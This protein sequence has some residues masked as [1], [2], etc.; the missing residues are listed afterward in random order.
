MANKIKKNNQH[1]SRP[2][3]I[4]IDETNNGTS[5]ISKNPNHP[6][7][8]IVTGYL[9]KDPFK[10]NYGSS[11]YEGKGW[12]FGPKSNLKNTQNR[13]RE[14]L[15]KYPDFYYTF[16]SRKLQQTEPMAILKARAI[17]IITLKFLLN[18]NLNPNSVKVVTDELDGSTNSKQAGFLI[19]LYLKQADLNLPSRSKRGADKTVV[20]VRKADTIG[21][22]ITGLHLNGN[23]HNWPH[24]S[25]KLHLNDLERLTIEIL[26]KD[27]EDY[28]DLE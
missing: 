11:R 28:P 9:M 15:S 2:W 23:N 17:S 27:Y 14:Y 21:Y 16:I 8:I 1:K 25:R 10:A 4:G 6:S 22:C 19:N 13:A 7:S 20:A 24:R 12:A 3:I 5:I 26:E 18:Y